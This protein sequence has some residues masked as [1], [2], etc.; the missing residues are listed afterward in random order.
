MI[1]RK[2]LAIEVLVLRYATDPRP[3]YAQIA[4]TLHITVG[5]VRGLERQGKRWVQQYGIFALIAVALANFQ[6]LSDTINT[7]GERF[8]ESVRALQGLDAQPK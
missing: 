5:Q 4:E 3:T 2:K 7:F 1:D 6:E 8:T